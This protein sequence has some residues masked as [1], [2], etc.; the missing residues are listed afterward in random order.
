VKNY[1]SKFLIA[2]SLKEQTVEEIAKAFVK[3]VVSIYGQ[4][5]VDLSE[6]G[7]NF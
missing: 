6:C 1:L 7:S 5:Q 3:K 2:A 4:P